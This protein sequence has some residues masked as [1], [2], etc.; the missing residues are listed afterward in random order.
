MSVLTK[1]IE[2]LGSEAE[3]W[4][5]NHDSDD[6]CAELE[7]LLASGTKLLS[8]LAEMDAESRE[9]IEDDSRGVDRVR[10]VQNLYAMFGSACARMN[11][12]LDDCECDGLVLRYAQAF[13]RACRDARPMALN[14]ER[15]DAA[16][17]AF[18]ELPAGHPGMSLDEVLDDLELRV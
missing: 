10:H 18:A 12:M 1:Q 8:L 14:P 15:L 9:R 2:V 17:A 16:E 4:E 6:A 3:R 7:E 11:E 5:A 13:R